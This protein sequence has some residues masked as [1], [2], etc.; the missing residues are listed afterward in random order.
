[1]CR[2][3][4][5]D[6]NAIASHV[7]DKIKTLD[8]ISRLCK[9]RIAPHGNKDKYKEHLKRDTQTCPPIGLRIVLSICVIF[10][11]SLVKID[12]KSAFPESGL[13]YNYLQPDH[14]ELRGIE[15]RGRSLVRYPREVINVR[16]GLVKEG[17]HTSPV[18]LSRSDV[19]EPDG[20]SRVRSLRLKG[21]PE[22]DSN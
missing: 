5:K 2:K 22:R 9:A 10:N 8:D 11:W 1:M 14:T 16:K 12:I 17:R 15:V 20:R 3:F 6:S 19:L 21:E 4:R 7:L 13:W 18:T